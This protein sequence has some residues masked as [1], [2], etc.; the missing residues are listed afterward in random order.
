MVND[1]FQI[2]YMTNSNYILSEILNCGGLISFFM[3]T[4]TFRNP[5]STCVKYLNKIFFLNININSATYY[6]IKLC[7]IIR[8]E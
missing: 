6:K 1:I 4:W 8:L 3:T 5:L 2:A 7:M